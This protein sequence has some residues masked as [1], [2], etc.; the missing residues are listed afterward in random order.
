VWC[1]VLWGFGQGAFGQ[2]GPW[3]SE[4]Y[5]VEMRSTA[6]STIFT[7]GRLIGSMAPYVVPVLAGTLG[8]LLDA[9]MLAVIGS[10]VTLLLAFVL[11]ET[12]G[13]PF[14]VVES[15]ERAA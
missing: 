9:M 5:P 1:Y 13:R 10:V 3:F 14:A 6:A 2:F 7:A 11:P 15:K 8:S 4:L 12:V